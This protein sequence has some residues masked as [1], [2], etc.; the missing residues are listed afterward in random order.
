MAVVSCNLIRIG[1]CLL[2]KDN[3]F[4]DRDMKVGIMITRHESFHDLY[5]YDSRIQDPLECLRNPT[6]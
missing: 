1:K 3:Q 4:Q 6:S 2:Y 5:Y